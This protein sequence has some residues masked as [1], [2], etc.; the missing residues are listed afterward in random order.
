[1]IVAVPQW[2]GRVSPV[3][4]V[5]SD[6]LLVTIEEKRE[7]QRNEINVVQE[8]HWARAQAMQKMGVELLICGA[9]SQPLQAALQSI[10]I[11]VIS[12]ICGPIETVLAA[13]REGRLDDNIFLMPGCCGRRRRLGGVRMSRGGGRRGR[14]Q[15]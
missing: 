8:E 11:Q 4:D 10:G 1:M 6:V 15:E 12:N 14:L 3:L 7:L 2:Q 9:I 13:F 5:A